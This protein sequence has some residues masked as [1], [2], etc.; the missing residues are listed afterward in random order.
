VV[1]KRPGKLS[2][3]ASPKPDFQVPGKSCHF[4]VFLI[5]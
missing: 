1:L 4:Q 5:K 3:Q 2:K